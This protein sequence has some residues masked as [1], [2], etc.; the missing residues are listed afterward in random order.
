M[1]FITHKTIEQEQLYSRVVWKNTAEGK[2]SH[3][4]SFKQYAWVFILPGRRNAQ[5][6]GSAFI[7]N[8]SVRYLE[9]PQLENW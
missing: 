6:Y 2:S 3:G 5:K 1:Y 7:Q 8:I 4:Q 9:G